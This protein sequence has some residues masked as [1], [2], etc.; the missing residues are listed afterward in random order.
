LTC[1]MLNPP[2]SESFFGCEQKI[3]VFGELHGDESVPV[4]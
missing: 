2:L 4:V 1:W 3:W